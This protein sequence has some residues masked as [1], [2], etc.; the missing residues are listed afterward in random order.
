[1]KIINNNYNT[2]NCAVCLPYLNTLQAHTII[3][4][5]VVEDQAGVLHC[6]IQALQTHVPKTGIF[7]YL[8]VYN[9][10]GFSSN[11]N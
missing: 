11:I 5:H 6:K 2:N 3:L 4:I 7:I 1:M 8:S 9:A 10:R